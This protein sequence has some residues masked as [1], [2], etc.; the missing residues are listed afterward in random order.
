MCH[1]LKNDLQIPDLHP[2]Q[3]FVDDQMG[4]MKSQ[5]FH[6]AQAPSCTSPTTYGESSYHNIIAFVNSLSLNASV[7]NL[8]G[9]ALLRITLCSVGQGVT[10]SITCS[11]HGIGA[12]SFPTFINVNIMEN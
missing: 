7:G 8:T 2:E 3:E 12:Y 4:V 1:S 5:L 10:V 11:V 9:S 6:T